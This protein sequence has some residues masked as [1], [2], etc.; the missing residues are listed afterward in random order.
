MTDRPVKR[1]YSRIERERRFLL[2]CLPEAIDAGDYRRLRDC[3]I[4]GA[5]LRLRRVERPDGSEIMT[6][7]GQKIVDPDAPQ[8]PRRRRMT[9]IYLSPGQ[10]ESL[11]ALDGPRAVK[12]RYRL[13]EQGW[14]WAV[15]VWE[16]PAVVAG[17][18]LAEVECGS[19]EELEAIRC[20]AWASRE[21][22]TEPAYSAIALARQGRCTPRSS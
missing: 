12:R 21:V 20:P 6:K 14:T 1:D 2:E 19:D 16:E 3:F 17:T 4:E 7:L 22:T 11:S 8:D 15:D 13:R 9:T 5:W 10:A 18:I